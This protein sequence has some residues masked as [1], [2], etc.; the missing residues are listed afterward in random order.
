VWP[1][2]GVEPVMETVDALMLV[3]GQ[4]PE[5]VARDHMDI[6]WET[7]LV[8]PSSS[9]ISTRATAVVVGKAQAELTIRSTREDANK[10]M[11]LLEKTMEKVYEWS[12]RIEA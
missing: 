9:P 1:T 12:E 7:V 2:D 8:S 3:E 11:L 4:A 6:E 10:I 5:E